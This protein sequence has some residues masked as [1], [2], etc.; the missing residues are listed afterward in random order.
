MAKRNSSDFLNIMIFTMTLAYQILRYLYENGDEE[1]KRMVIYVFE[2][3]AIKR[4][5]MP[6]TYKF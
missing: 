6:G 1:M 3:E 4:G 5:L 2:T